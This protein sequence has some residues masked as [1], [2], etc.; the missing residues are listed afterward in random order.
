MTLIERLR[1]IHSALDDALGDTDVTHI[2]DDDQLREEEPI[3]W[4]AMRLAE[5]IESLCRD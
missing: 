3:Q 2:E 5:L 1:E 4:A